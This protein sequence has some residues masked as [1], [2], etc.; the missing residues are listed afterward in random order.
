MP[1]DA[2]RTR[3]MRALHKE[4][5]QRG[6]SHDALHDVCRQKFGVAS[7]A[8]LNT[9]QLKTVFQD[10]TGNLFVSRKVKLPARGYGK[11]GELEIVSPELLETLERAFAKRAWG[12]ETKRNFIRRQ[13]RGREEIRTTA[14]LQKVFRGVQA[15]NRRAGLDA[16]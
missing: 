9:G 7:M 8:D 13:L 11:R 10:L 16:A 4:A 2:T 3:L 15:M 6:L 1:K 5:A 12:P 14:D